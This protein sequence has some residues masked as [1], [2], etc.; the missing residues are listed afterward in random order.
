MSWTQFIAAE[1]VSLSRHDPEYEQR[2]KHKQPPNFKAAF[3]HRQNGWYTDTKGAFATFYQS[4][5]Q[6]KLGVLGK[7]SKQQHLTVVIEQG[8]TKT[9]IGFYPKGGNLAVSVFKHMDGELWSPDPLFNSES[10]SLGLKIPMNGEQC[11]RFNRIFRLNAHKCRLIDGATSSL[12]LPGMDC[13]KL[14]RF[15]CPDP[16]NYSLFGWG[17]YDNCITWLIH[18]FP[19]LKNYV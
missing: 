17:G 5:L 13:T 12:C 16:R 8:K 1:A 18:L 7:F 2:K 14:D 10:K 9:S 6:G 19:R 15:E 3:K 11:T 4:P